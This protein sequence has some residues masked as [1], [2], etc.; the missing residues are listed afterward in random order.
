MATPKI[1]FHHEDREG[2]K[3]PILL[4]FQNFVFFVSLVMNCY[5]L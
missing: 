4:I 3:V 2:Q 1:I 5:F